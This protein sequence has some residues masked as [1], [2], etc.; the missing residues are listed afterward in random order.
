M[1]AGAIAGRRKVVC[2]VTGMRRILLAIGCAADR[3]PMSRRRLKGLA[4]VLAICV[5]PTP[6]SAHPLDPL[7]PDE[8]RAAARI[9]RMDPR[10]SQAQ[11][12]SILLNEP[13]KAQ[14]NAWRPGQT[15]AREAR[16]V[17]DDDDERLRSRRQS[18]RRAGRLRRRA[19]RRRTASYGIRVRGRES[20]S[21]TSGIP[22]RACQA[23]RDGHREAVLFAD[24]GRLLRDSRARRQARRQGWLL[25]PP[26]DDD[27]HV[28]LAHR[29]AVHH[30]RF[31]RSSKS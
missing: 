24:D 26:K 23:R 12:A 6:G 27:E 4:L 15:V 19:Q 31:A 9:A 17:V 2:R 20:R 14:V 29:T 5:V 30:R 3:R 22:R 21:D 18:H 1:A 16:L 11:F 8:I 28:G 25:R 10:L 7:T 13:A